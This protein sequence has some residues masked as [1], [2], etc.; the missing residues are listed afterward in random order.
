[1]PGNRS[2]VWNSV[3]SMWKPVLSAANH[4]RCTFMPPKKRTLTL[5]SAWRLQGQPQ[6]SSCTI[7]AVH[8][9]TKSCTASWSHSHSPPETVSSKWFASESS[10]RTTPAEPPSA[11]TVWLRIGTTFDS[12][13]TRSPASACTAAMAARR[14]AP[15]PPTTTTSLSMTSMLP[16]SLH[17]TVPGH[18]SGRSRACGAGC[19]CG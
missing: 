19:G 3:C 10:P 15:P 9:S 13:A 11:A 14:P 5:P 16:P 12:S 7:S 6:C 8:C 17:P 4:V 1:M 2:E 18:R